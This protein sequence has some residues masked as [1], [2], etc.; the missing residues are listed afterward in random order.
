MMARCISLRKKEA[1]F[2]LTP[3]LPTC[4]H[5]FRSVSNLINVIRIVVS[6]HGVHEIPKRPV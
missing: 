5:I 2:C 6:R 4:I 1:A 3:Y